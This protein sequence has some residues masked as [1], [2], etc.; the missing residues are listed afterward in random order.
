MLSSQP[1]CIPTLDCCCLWVTFAHSC[2]RTSYATF[3]FSPIVLLY[4]HIPFCKQACTYCDFHFTTSVHYKADLVNALIRE[5]HVRQQELTGPLRS[6]YFGG[7]T[8]SLLEASELEKL[9]EA[10]HRLFGIQ[11]NAEITLEANPDDLTKA[12]LLELKASGINR[13]SIGVQSFFEEDLR[14]MNRAHSPAEALRCIEDAAQVGF[15]RL[16]IDL[17]YG[18]PGLTDDRWIQNLEKAASLPVNHLSCYALTVEPNTPLAKGILK[19]SYLNPEEEQAAGQFEIL[20]QKAPELGFLHYE[21]SNLSRGE[22]TAIH[23]SAYWEG[24]SYLGI[25]PSAHSF[26]GKTRRVNIPN[27]TRYIRD[28]QTGD[29]AHELE[30]IDQKTRY[31]ELVL[32]GL[33]T[34]RGIDKSALIRLG[35]EAV[36]Q[37]SKARH[38]LPNPAVILESETTFRLDPAHWLLAD[39][40]AGRLF[41]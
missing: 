18:T 13:L 9:M 38:Q 21:I 34:L 26:D 10:I 16:S 8:P 7:G 4:L 3:Q 2:R 5:M 24:R 20:Q 11:D 25:G 22:A 37:F 15:D 39:G 29:C 23:N 14:F 17:I 40:I 27:N 28:L 31:N 32:T 1:N 12:K 41:Q 36:Q 30:V 19:G 6:I 33:R 35:K